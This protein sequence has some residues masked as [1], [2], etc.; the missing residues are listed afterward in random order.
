MAERK[1]QNNIDN[2]Y[3]NWFIDYASY[4]IL[5][6]AIPRIEDGL[7][8]VQRRILHSMHEI[9]DSRFHKVANIIGNTMKY[10]PHGDAAIG[11]ALVNIGQK[12]FLVETQGNW[13]DSITGDKAAAPRYIESKL[14]NISIDTVFNKD[15]TNY[16]KSYDGRNKE[17]IILPA[18]LPLLLMQ[19][20]EGIAVGLSTKILPHNFNEIVKSC[21]LYLKDKNFSLYPDFQSGGLIDV[22]DYKSG[23]RGGRIKIRSKIDVIDKTNILISSIPYGITST[24]LIDSIIRANE[25][26]KIKIKKIEDNSAKDIQ[27]NILLSKGVSPTVTVDALY[28]FTN[29]EI[30]LSPNC[31][32]IK[33]EK[34]QFL[35]V[36][37]LLRESVDHALSVFKAE[38]DLEKNRIEEKWHLLNL[39]KIFINNKIYLDIEECETWESVIDTIRHKINPHIKILKREVSNEDIYKLTEIKIRKITKFDKSKHDSHID[40]LDESL[41][42]VMNN[43]NHLKEYAIRFFDRILKKYGDN[44]NR[45]TEISTFDKVKA[46]NVAV[47]NKKLYVNSKEGFIGYGIKDGEYIADCSD[48]DLVI[49]FYSDGKYMVTNIKDKQYIGKNIIDVAIWKKQDKHRIYN[50]IYKDGKTGFSYAKRFNVASLIKDREYYMTGGND[51]SKI[52][53]FSNNP[54]SESELVEVRIKS[55]SKARKKIFEYDFADISIKNR[56]SKGNLVTKYP[57]FK[58][59][60]KEVGESTLGGRKIW[61]DNTI[62][63][64]NLDGQGDYL[65]SFNSD[66]LILSISQDG[67]YELSSTDFSKRYSMKE[68]MLIEKF[69]SNKTYSVVYKNGRSRDYYIKRFKIETSTIDRKFSLTQDISHSKIA[70]VTS[71]EMHLLKFNFFTKKGDKRAKEIDIDSFVSIKN[72]KAIGNKLI[73]Y[74]RL[75]SFMIVEKDTQKSRDGND[76]ENMELTLF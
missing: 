15:V 62:G 50:L 2:L 8:P 72:W 34:P 29:C 52:H 10:H 41:K 33:D 60:H 45:K 75:S 46:T 51:G 6:R 14:S 40:T 24:S 31:C 1:N 36:K 5:E 49:A 61:L 57:V 42:E 32:V 73:G 53:Y 54:N 18:K 17:P 71:K 70:A 11:D 55:K 22:S 25:S 19:G 37:D 20:A 9:H 38:L 65:G 7:K 43:L 76:S 68:L 21:I 74:K 16:Q 48:I 64:L 13:G 28:A 66:D 35:N 30:S 59:Y 56:A 23:K 3:K 26:G 12:G 67:S 69:D 39:E 4:V 58:V 63:K 27:I 44:Y 47:T